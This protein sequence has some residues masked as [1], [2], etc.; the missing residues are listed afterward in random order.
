MKKLLMTGFLLSLVLSVNVLADEQVQKTLPALDR[1]RLAPIQIPQNVE[2][3]QTA[4]QTQTPAVPLEQKEETPQ[5]SDLNSQNINVEVPQNSK[6]T[7]EEI[8]KAQE[9]VESIFAPVEL[10]VE[11][12]T[13][14]S[15]ETSEIPAAD[16]NTDINMLPK[17]EKVKE[18]PIKN[19][20]SKY[21]KEVKEETV[22]QPKEE[23]NEQTQTID[24]K[25]VEEPNI[26]QNTEIKEQ[27]DN[28]ISTMPLEP[29]KDTLI[30]PSVNEVK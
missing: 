23:I 25:Q 7:Q 17:K 28:P 10:N 9:N 4:Q 1:L 15:S 27:T 12:N 26:K 18:F 3:P 6:E 24:E 16:K 5:T 11:N 22:E 8:Q 2:T 30:V 21:K 14:Q 29:S 19:I 20:F 13:N